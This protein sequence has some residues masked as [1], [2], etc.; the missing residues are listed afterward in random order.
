MRKDERQDAQSCLSAL[1]AVSARG[2]RVFHMRSRIS[3]TEAGHRSDSMQAAGSRWRLAV[4]AMLAA[5]ALLATASAADTWQVRTTG[6]G[7]RRSVDSTSSIHVGSPP[8]KQPL[9]AAP[10]ARRDAATASVQLLADPG[11]AR[12]LQARG[13]DYRRE[14]DTALAWLSRLSPGAPVALRLTFVA[15]PLESRVEHRHRGTGTIVDLAFSFAS[16]PGGT[17]S[18]QVGQALG[19]ALHEASHALAPRGLSRQDDEYRASL[20]E[21][22]YLVDTLR[23]GDRMRLRAPATARDGEYFVTAQSRRAA[24]QVVRDLTGAAGGTTVAWDDRPALLGLR[25]LCRIRLA[26]PAD[27]G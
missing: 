15:E 1:R 24:A 23:P 26:M 19:V 12:S 10:V 6:N 14:L 21:A 20:V 17:P 18:V 8:R 4:A 9:Q 3:G 11:A 13:V 27:R 25:T 5:A 2:A 22:C 7:A 16:T